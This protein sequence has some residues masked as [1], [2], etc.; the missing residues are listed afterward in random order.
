MDSLKKAVPDFITDKQEQ[1]KYL[2][3]INKTIYDLD[4]A[5]RLEKKGNM[6][7]AEK[8]KQKAADKMQKWYPDLLKYQSDRLSDE[9]KIKAAGVTAGK[10][11]YSDKLYKD[12]FTDLVQNKGM[13]PK[14]PATA[15]LARKETASISGLTGE[16]LDIQRE[17]AVIKGEKD[18]ET[19][20][21]LKMDRYGTDEGSKERA[22]IDAKISAEKKKIRDNVFKTPAADEK[23][24]VTPT[25]VPKPAAAPAS[26]VPPAPDISTVTGAPAGSGIGAYVKGQGYEI[27]DKNGKLLGYAQ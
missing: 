7:E 4:N 14:D 27:R 8:I 26:V 20:K 1:R 22:D 15:V 3:E 23:P 21:A 9:A 19:L 10:D 12:V 16:K 25:P 13:D 18:S 24:A 17:A 6:D 11:T 5:V 2:K